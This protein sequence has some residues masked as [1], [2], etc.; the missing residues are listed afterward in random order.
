MENEGFTIDDS[1][2]EKNIFAGILNANNNK[3]QELLRNSPGYQQSRIEVQ[4]KIKTVRQRLHPKD[5]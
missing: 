4:R 2:L 5:L 1:H 3:T